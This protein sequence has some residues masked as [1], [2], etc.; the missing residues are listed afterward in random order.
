MS[1]CK[2]CAFKLCVVLEK[3]V[4]VFLVIIGMY[5]L[6]ITKQKVKMWQVSTIT[7]GEEDRQALNQTKYDVLSEMLQ[8]FEI[9]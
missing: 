1:V 7:E 5:F 2:C 3:N 4:P 9:F 6:V 8:R